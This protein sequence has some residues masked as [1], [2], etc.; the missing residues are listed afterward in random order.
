MKEEQLKEIIRELY[1]AL[2]LA[3]S[4]EEL[5]ETIR[6]LKL[7]KKEIS[8]LGIESAMKFIHACDGCKNDDTDYCFYCMHGYFGSGKAEYVGGRRLVD[9]SEY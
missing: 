5:G 4:D 2:K 1:E 3:V 6:D 7:N 9:C 8:E